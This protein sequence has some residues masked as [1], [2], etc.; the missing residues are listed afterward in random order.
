M[1]IIPVIDLMNGLVVHARKG[2]RDS[3][4]PIRTPL[5]RGASP[6]AVIDGLLGLH[7]FR[8]LYVADLDALMGRGDQ[9]ALI[10]R[11]QQDYPSL[12]FWVDRGLPADG[13]LDAS[14]N[15]LPVIGS[16]SLK[17]GGL[18]DVNAMHDEFILSLDFTA[19]CLLGPGNIL[20]DSKLWPERIIVMSLSRVGAHE[21]P[22]FQRLEYFTGRWPKKRFFAAGGVRHAKDLRRL[23]ESWVSGVLL[24]SALHSGAIGSSVLGTFDSETRGALPP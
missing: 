20:D 23:K 22:D 12:Q 7:N 6:T 1:Q 10:E 2:Q 17:D 18:E 5:C 4:R 11:L 24:A 19:E 3:Y 16:E 13:L 15:G 8:T 14:L 21:G 9:R